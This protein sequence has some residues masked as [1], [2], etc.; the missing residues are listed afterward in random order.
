MPIYLCLCLV[1]LEK[2]KQ[3]KIPPN[4]LQ[5]QTH[6]IVSGALGL[7]D[8]LGIADVTIALCEQ[9]SIHYARRL[10]LHLRLHKN[11]HTHAQIYTNMNI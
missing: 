10:H 11:T 1:M 2:R 4:P 3:R 9:A 5:R 6:L 8:Q 7:G